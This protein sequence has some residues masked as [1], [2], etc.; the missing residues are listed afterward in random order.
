MEEELLPI[1]ILLVPLRKQLEDPQAEEEG[2]EAE[3]DMENQETPVFTPVQV[4]AEV[5]DTPV[6]KDKEEQVSQDWLD[7]FG[8]TCHE[9]LRFD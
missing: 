3:L 9:L 7:L 8:G 5:E 1:I 4:E 6:Y 2:E